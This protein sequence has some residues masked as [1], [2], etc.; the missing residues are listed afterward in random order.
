[1][2]PVQSAAA[3]T[4]GSPYRAVVTTSKTVASYVINDTNFP[5]IGKYLPCYVLVVGATP[6]N[7][8][9][10]HS[11]DNG[12]NW[13]AGPGSG[14]VVYADAAGVT[15]SPGGVSTS[16]TVRVNVGTG[17]TSVHLLPIAAS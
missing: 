5:G 15:G 1:M 4:S 17:T 8:T 9:I 11:I 2:L 6:A 3:G 12:S 16:Q 14:S 10:S 13:L 7:V